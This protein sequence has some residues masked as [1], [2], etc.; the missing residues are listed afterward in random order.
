MKKLLLFTFSL[1]YLFSF[2]AYALDVTGL[3]TE[4]Y[5]NPVGIDKTSIHFSWQLQSEQRGVVQTAYSIQIANDAAFGNVVWE[6]GNVNS[7][8][9]VFIT[10][11]K[12][13]LR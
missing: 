4:D 13:M 6:S 8:Q 9:S 3:R 11:G 12:K 1:F 5:H 2:S 7:D 10:N